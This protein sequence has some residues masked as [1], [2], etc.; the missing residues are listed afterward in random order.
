MPV[1]SPHQFLK[2]ET[3]TIGTSEPDQTLW[4]SEVGQL[5]QFGA[6][7]E[8]LQPG[9]R[10][11]KKHWHSKEDEMIYVL[12]GEITVIE[13]AHE[14]VLHPGDVATFLA[15]V[16]VGHFLE[17]RSQSPTKCLVVG[18]R[19]PFDTIT[20]PD[21]ARVCHRDRSQPEDIWTDLQGVPAPS[22]HSN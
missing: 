4:I 8:I 22:P 20:Y 16:A 10:S 12:E 21:H 5:T 1:F 2:E 3:S 6:F 9:S 11:S 19:A 18:P 17:N 15:N 13:G 14:S 7:I